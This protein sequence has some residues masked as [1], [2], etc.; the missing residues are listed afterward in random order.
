VFSIHPPSGIAPDK[1]NA[2]ILIYY[3]IG[4]NTEK[5]SPAG[6]YFKKNE[7]GYYQ[8]NSYQFII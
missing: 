6:W 4:Q 2:S 1:K 8:Q 5:I 7:R 3:A